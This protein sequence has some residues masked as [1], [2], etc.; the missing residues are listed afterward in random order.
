MSKILLVTWTLGNILSEEK[1]Y[2]AM[3]NVATTLTLFKHYFSYVFY[4][5]ILYLQP[6]QILKGKQT[7]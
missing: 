7:L 4:L 2:F 1:C 6:F 5:Y 3:E